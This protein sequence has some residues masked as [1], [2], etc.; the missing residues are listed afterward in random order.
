MVSPVEKGSRHGRVSAIEQ[1]TQNV[2]HRLAVGLRRRIV[3]HR[4]R[5]WFGVR[6]LV[7]H[8]NAALAVRPRR[9][10][11]GALTS[12]WAGSALALTLAQTAQALLQQIADGLAE[13][14]ARLAALPAG[15]RALAALLSTI[16]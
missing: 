2:V 8:R 4:G 14:I 9:A 1:L 16:E 10:L 7:R 6:R 11:T 15:R 3:R 5:G 12:T 13:Q